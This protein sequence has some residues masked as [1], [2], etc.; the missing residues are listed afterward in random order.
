M[1]YGV[2]HGVRYVLNMDV[3]VPPSAVLARPGRRDG[4]RRQR[5]GRCD[6]RLAIRAGGGVEVAGRGS[7]TSGEPGRQYAPLG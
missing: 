5:R 1:R 4:S 6:D 3:I 2:E 7:D